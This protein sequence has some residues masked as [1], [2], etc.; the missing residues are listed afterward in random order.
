MQVNAA[1]SS[2]RPQAPIYQ[3]VMLSFCLFAIGV[4]AMRSMVRLDPQMSSLL[5]YADNAVCVVFFVDFLLSLWHS[6]N[7]LR[8]FSTWGWTAC[9]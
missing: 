6:P 1:S 5:D 2:A 3:L 8:Y 7:R 9:A 4:L